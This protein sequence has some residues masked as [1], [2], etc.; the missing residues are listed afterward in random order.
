MSLVFKLI[1][2]GTPYETFELFFVLS[3]LMVF[4]STVNLHARGRS[5]RHRADVS[6]VDFACN[7]LQGNED[8]LQIGLDIP[9][10]LQVFTFLKR[11][12]LTRYN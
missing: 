9:S 5:D 8:S 6:S 2:E 11:W 7:I 3:Y 4:L 1:E 10:G 12:N